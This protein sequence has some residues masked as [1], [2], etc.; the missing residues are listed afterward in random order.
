MKEREKKP[1]SG[2]QLRNAAGVYWLLDMEQSGYPYKPPMILNEVGADIWNMIGNGKS[3][4]QIVDSLSREY[5]VER[6]I[7]AKDV[8]AFWDKLEENGILG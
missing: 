2:Y 1:Y 3:K 4:E 8:Q 6:S 5:Q 7:I